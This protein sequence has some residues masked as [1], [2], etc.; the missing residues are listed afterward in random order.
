ME[1]KQSVE[2][3]RVSAH[4]PANIQFTSGT[5]GQPKVKIFTVWL[6]QYPVDKNRFLATLKN[7]VPYRIIFSFL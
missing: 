5:T 6:R 7:H 3:L 2:N 1:A 4:S